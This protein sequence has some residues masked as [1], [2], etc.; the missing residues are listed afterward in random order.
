MN[1]FLSIIDTFIK[2]ANLFIFFNKTETNGPYF[3]LKFSFTHD[4]KSDFL[5]SKYFIIS[6]IEKIAFSHFFSF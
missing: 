3:N 1:E 2:T 6:V 4:S 5:A